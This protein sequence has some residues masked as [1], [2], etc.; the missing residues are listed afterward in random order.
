MSDFPHANL[1]VGKYLVSPLVRP[2]DSGDYSA[3][4]S[5]KS[6]CGSGTHDRVLRLIGRFRTQENAHRHALAEGLDY[7]RP[8]FAALGGLPPCIPGIA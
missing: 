6:G 7:L 2:T 8:R 5:I 1:T 3:S 4:V